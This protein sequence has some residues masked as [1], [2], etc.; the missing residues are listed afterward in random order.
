ML[1]DKCSCT[2][3]GFSACAWFKLG[4]ESDAESTTSVSIRL[5]INLSSVTRSGYVSVTVYRYLGATGPDKA[6]LKARLCAKWEQV[7]CHVCSKRLYHP[8]SRHNIHN[9]QFNNGSTRRRRRKTRKSRWECSWSPSQ[10]RLS[11]TRLVES[12]ARK[13]LLMF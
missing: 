5:R 1:G 12:Q 10:S 4:T 7:I 2:Q 3:L 6:L 13:R 11:S 9:N 8:H